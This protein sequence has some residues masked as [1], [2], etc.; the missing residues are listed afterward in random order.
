[1]HT[2]IAYRC[3]FQ[4]ISFKTKIKVSN[5]RKSQYLHLISFNDCFDEW[6][7]INHQPEEYKLSRDGSL[8]RN[9]TFKN[10]YFLMY[11]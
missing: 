4:L 3:S 9:I 2:I 5:I 7:C 8:D 10:E 11:V 6:I 1:M